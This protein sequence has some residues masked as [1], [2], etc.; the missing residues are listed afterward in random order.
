MSEHHPE[1]L[2]NCDYDVDKAKRGIVYIDE[3]D[4]ISRKS[5]NLRSPGMFRRRRAAGFLK[6]V[7]GTRLPRCRPQGG[8]STRTRDSSRSTP[9]NIPSIC[10]GAFDGLE[11]IV[12]NRTEKNGI[13]FAGEVKHPVLQGHL[14]P[15]ARRSNGKTSSS[16][17]LF[18][19]RR[20]LCRC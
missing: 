20:P 17:G 7:E 12:R 16:T 2:Q 6:L 5:D 14:R 3:I 8:R 18:R 9:T 1:L 15:A 19:I 13:G 11:T 4:K 10:G